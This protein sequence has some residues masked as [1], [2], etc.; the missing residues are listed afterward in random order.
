[1]YPIGA[2]EIVIAILLIWNIAL[3]YL[4]WRERSYLREL[5]PKT[6]ERDIRNKFKELLDEVEGFKRNEAFLNKNLRI[7]AKQG[8]SHLQ[9]IATSRYNPYEDTG[10]DQSFSVA[11]IDG[12]LNGILLTSLHSRAGTRIYTK[13]IVSGKSDLELSKEEKEVLKKVLEG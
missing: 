1:M 9:K 3:T 8:L 7:L 6:Q 2:V 5:F 12:N 11:L 13:Q 10:G 4:F